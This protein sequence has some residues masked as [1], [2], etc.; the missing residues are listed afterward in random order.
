V[1]ET[2][3]QALVDLLDKQIQTI[4]RITSQTLKFHRENGLPAEFKLAELIAELV[5]FFE[6][7]ARAQGVTLIQRLEAEGKVVGFGGEIRQVV[8]NLLLNAIEATPSDG[9]VTVHLYETADWRR[10]ES[11]GYRITIADN[12][13]GI[14]AQHR[15]RI[16]EPF[17]TTKGDK[18][19]GLGLW[20]SMGIV[21]R[22]GGSIHVWSTQR[23][24]RSG[25][26]FSFFLP[27]Q[28]PLPELP[29]R[30]R[31]DSGSPNIRIA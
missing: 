11:R 31:Y 30:R 1:T 22:A 18:G 27:T 15:L 7:K 20:V 4:S 8:S 25:T 2:S 6:P 28:V 3:T 5:E 13:G 17:F 9:C 26:C 21:D 23:P 24:G 12:G 14:D 16:F 19:T 10:R 29:G